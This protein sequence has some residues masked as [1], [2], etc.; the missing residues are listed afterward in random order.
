MEKPLPVPIEV[1]DS[2]SLSLLSNI[3]PLVIIIIL[4]L[5]KFIKLHLFIA[6]IVSPFIVMTKHEGAINDFVSFHKT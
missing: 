5:V 6:M 4:P 1:Y 2:K 3:V